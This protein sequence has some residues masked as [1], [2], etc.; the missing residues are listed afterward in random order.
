MDICWNETA[1]L[2][3]NPLNI[4]TLIR[5][6]AQSNRC[7]TNTVNEDLIPSIQD[8]FDNE[9]FKQIISE[10]VIMELTAESPSEKLL[11]IQVELLY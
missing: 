1:P 3:P 9:Q 5:L 8:Q 4:Q 10:N 2:F 7:P 11:G 6:K